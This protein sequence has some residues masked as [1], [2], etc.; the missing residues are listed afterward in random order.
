MRAEARSRAW[1][2]P[3]VG[4]CIG[5]ALASAA[6]GE[7]P[8][9]PPPTARTVSFV[10]DIQPILLESCLR[11]HGL[12]RPKSGF[13]LTDRDSAL[14]GGSHGV[15]IVSGRSADSPLIRYVAGQVEDMEMPPAGKG[16]PLIP[17]QVALL[18]AWI[19]QGV[20]WGARAAT[21][22]SPLQVEVTPVIGGS[23]VR[24]NQAKFRE[25]EAQP[26]GWTGGVE[27]FRL[28]EDLP[29]AASWTLEGKLLRDDYRVTLGLE[30][31]DLGFAHFGFE[32]ARNYA[33]A[34]GGY[35][36]PF[37]PPAFGVNEG[38]HLDTGKAWA[39]LGLV[40]PNWP[41]M[42]LGYQYQFREGDK[43]ML[44]WGSVQ[45]GAGSFQDSRNIYPSTKQIDEHTQVLRLDL[46]Y[47][48]HG[49]LLEDNL[50]A[51][52]EDLSTRRTDAIFVP[53][54]QTTPALLSRVS[55]GRDDV[56]V[57]NAF[58][59]T[60]QI[61]PW[62][63][64]SGGY[65]FASLDGNASVRLETVDGSGQPAAG[66]AWYSQEILLN[67]TSH[68]L[69]LN[70]QWLP[71]K[72]LTLG[73]GLQGDWVHQETFGDLRL[74]ELLDPNDP[75][76][77]LQTVPALA[78]A[79][80]DRVGAEQDLVVRYTGLPLTVLFAEAR[81]N[82]GQW[83]LAKDLSGGD[84]AF[85]LATEAVS[86]GQAYRAGFTVSPWPRVS[87][88]GYYTRRERQVDYHPSLDDHPLGTGS[89]AGYPAFI[90]TRALT[91]DET[92]ARLVLRPNNLLRTSVSVRWLTT[93]YRTTTDATSAA[94]VGEVGTPGG[95]IQAGHYEAWIASAEVTWTP[96]QRL[97]LSGTF[98]YQDPELTTASN[99]NPSVAPYRGNIYAAFA[100]LGYA[101]DGRTDAYVRYAFSLSDYGQNNVA[102]GLPLGL[103]YERNG[104]QVGF[105][106]RLSPQ[107]SARLQYGFVDYQEPSRGSLGDYTAH[108]VLASLSLRWP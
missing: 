70:S 15:D 65:R 9:L 28:H 31:R 100:T 40:L 32:Q 73:L 60:K 54:G 38:L 64:L 26:N 49:Y 17:E 67:Q 102:D 21:N 48:L 30:K 55:E 83:N 107:A 51:E 96:L 25:M 80:L 85:A 8:P 35:Y 99:G 58:R 34:T 56:E 106:R 46:S 52:F 66:D 45:Y 79:N 94:E 3:A 16:Q 14:K 75:T 24:G 88:H 57:A 4:I 2:R 20:S 72:Q 86:L 39:E 1:R 53:A 77:G 61:A 95:T 81:L 43:P 50:R 91:T 103:D 97:F 108:Q 29:G 47:D 71:L 7:T 90:N 78:H 22:A 5:L 27:P 89:S 62:W 98:S 23:A 84:H 12:E 18:R 82:E 101:L 33:E 59:V 13:R 87:L 69:N 41:R 63:Q 11:C 105:V 68:T 92:G 37:D 6:V 74:D 42:V 10:D 104:I 36:A 76:A 44:S 19:D 93:D